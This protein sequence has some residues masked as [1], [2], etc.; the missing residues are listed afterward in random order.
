MTTPEPAAPPAPAAAAPVDARVTALEAEQQRQGGVLDEIRGLL[1]GDGKGA[2]AAPP[3]TGTDPPAG[4][5]D[6]TEQMKQA[7]RAVQAED[8]AALGRN[9][10]LGTGRAPVE[11]SPRE[12]LVRGKD[13]L[14]NGLFG[15]GDGK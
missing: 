3:V 12:V 10:R 4:A 1:K 11:Q 13:R 2:P 7:V 5:P 6:I 14:Q 9:A 8:D 15:K